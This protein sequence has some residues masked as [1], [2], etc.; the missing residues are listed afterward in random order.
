MKFTHI[1]KGLLQGVRASIQVLI[2][3]H[4][5][6]SACGAVSE[7]VTLP[8]HRYRDCLLDQALSSYFMC[9][10]QSISIFRINH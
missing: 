8:A 1:V 5:F 9:C 7:E 6:Y 2:N 3:P 4:V 10:L